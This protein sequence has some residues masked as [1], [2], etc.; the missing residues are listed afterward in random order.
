MSGNDRPRGMPL[1][2]GPPPGPGGSE[3]NCRKCGKDIGGIF[4]R[5]RRCQ[6]CGFKYCSSCSDYQ[7]LMPRQG[8]DQSGYDVVN[9][10]GFCIDYLNITASSPS[11]LR[12]QKLGKLKEYLDAYNVDRKGAL[13][14]DDLINTIVAARGQ[15]GCL[16][17]ENEEYYRRHSVPNNA[18][19]SPNRNFFQRTVDNA[20]NAFQNATS[21]LGSGSGSAGNR[22]PPQQQ[23]P[24]PQFYPPYGHPPYPQPGPGYPGQQYHYQYP[25]YGY[26]PQPYPYAGAGYAPPPG[27]PPPNWQYPHPQPA[28]NASPYS[29][30]AASASHHNLNT[31]Q[32]ASFGPTSPR[33]SSQSQ[34]Q[35][36]PRTQSASASAPPPRPP[37]PQRRDTDVPTLERLSDMPRED[38]AKLSVH[39]LKEVLHRNHVLPGPVLEKEELV[40]K[41]VRMVEEERRERE[42]ADAMRAREEEAMR[43]AREEAERAREE[44]ER[45]R[46]E[47]EREREAAKEREARRATVEDVEDEGSTN[48]AEAETSEEAPSEQPGE[49]GQGAPLAAEGTPQQTTPAAPRPLSPR[50]KE[51]AATLERN[52]LCVICQDEEANIAIVDCGH[53][54]MC[55][56][57]SDLVMKSTRE[58]PL[59][60]TRIVT[61]QRLLR[62]YRT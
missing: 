26:P 62:I 55:R 23:H 1:L 24:Q 29:R 14:K 40:N 59:C 3:K 50:A 39:V 53:L 46:E 21:N 15:D 33:P 54:C 6:H 48:G 18:P 61:E 5:A 19:A 45:E 49:G 12:T 22:P 44:R 17:Y 41:V 43:I 2:S 36:R 28:P 58:C 8:A 42:R 34:Q 37:P 4:T 31:P 57:C 27:A 9:V 38:V 30:P 10:C 13:E 7:A 47:R 11:Q 16:P 60:R 35:G 20:T 32:T 52:G 51:M 56:D 25:Q